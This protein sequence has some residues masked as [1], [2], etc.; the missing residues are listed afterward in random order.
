MPRCSYDSTL[1][2]ALTSIATSLYGELFSSEA[3]VRSLVSLLI[4]REE[5][6]GRVGGERKGRSER[7]YIVCVCAC[8]V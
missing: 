5:Q 6:G 4:W 3:T 8:V 2:P 1:L 7:G